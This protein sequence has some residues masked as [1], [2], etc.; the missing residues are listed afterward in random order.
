MDRL[1][2]DR[3][4]TET[5]DDLDARKEVT[6]SMYSVESHGILHRYAD[7]PSKSC[8]KNLHNPAAAAPVRHLQ[9]AVQRSSTMCVTA[10]ADEST[11]KKAHAPSSSTPE[12][13]WGERQRR[14]SDASDRDSGTV[15]RFRSI[16]EGLRV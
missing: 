3:L 15:A 12:Q 6:F 8:S 13:P 4:S 14:S 10:A 7:I 16:W 11:L 2:Q 1:I 5:Q 9:T